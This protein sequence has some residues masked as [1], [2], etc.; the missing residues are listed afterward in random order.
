MTLGHHAAPANWSVSAMCGSRPLG[1]TLSPPKV[2]L[3]NGSARL[4]RPC[5]KAR[6]QVDHVA[7]AVG[8]GARFVATP[9][10]SWPISV[11]SRS[12]LLARKGVMSAHVP[13]NI[14]TGEKR[15]HDVACRAG[16]NALRTTE[17]SDRDPNAH[18]NRSTFQRE[19]RHLALSGKAGIST[20]PPAIATELN[21]V[22]ATDNT[23]S[24]E[25]TISA[26]SSALT[27][28]LVIMS[29]TETKGNAPRLLVHRRDLRRPPG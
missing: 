20:S 9:T 17:L 11:A 29:S 5:R 23:F 16:W 24:K 19:P 7:A 1:G 6:D 12:R 28:Q 14:A 4:P 3:S 22:C 13:I 18:E 26:V 25:P 15:P 21:R 8:E 2:D 27:A 10:P